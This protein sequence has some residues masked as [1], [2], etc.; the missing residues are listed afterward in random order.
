MAPVLSQEEQEEREALIAQ[1]A[2]LKR[3]RDDSEADAEYR[4]DAEARLR[5]GAMIYRA[6]AKTRHV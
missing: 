4:L 2:E 1:L 3:R 6:I 5:F